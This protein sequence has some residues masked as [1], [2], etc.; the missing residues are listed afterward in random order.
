MRD[1]LFVFGQ[2]P[3]GREGLTLVGKS[4]GHQLVPP[5]DLPTNASWLVSWIT[6]LTG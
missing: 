1:K 3:L 5:A 2:L 6:A 4:A